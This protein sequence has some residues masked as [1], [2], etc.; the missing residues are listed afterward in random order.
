MAVGFGSI[1]TAIANESAD[2]S[3]QVTLTKPAGLAAGELMIAVISYSD[4]VETQF[5]ALTGWTSHTLSQESG[6]L[7]T[8]IL[9]KVADAGD[10]AASDFTFTKTAGDEVVNLCAA[11]MRITGSGFSGL[12]NITAADSGISSDA[13][14]VY[15]GGVTPTAN[16][17]LIMIATSGGTTATASTYAIVTSDPTWTERAELTS[18]D[19]S[20]DNN[21]VIAT[22]V[23]TEATATGNFSLTW[24]ADPGESVGFLFSI[25]ESTNVTVSP[26]V[27]T[28]T[29][30][31]QAPTVS[32]GAT[33]SP[34]VITMTATIQ[35]PTVTLTDPKWTNTD[36][37]STSWVNQDKN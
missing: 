13:A 27:I 5:F 36:K 28:A 30:S 6:D 12:G 1:T 2:N 33:V 22:A 8:T 17:L 29:L 4:T 15:T 32:G 3:L 26:S 11:L 20:P 9:W 10:A 19:S 31:V 18:I 23:R 14:A 35:A 16:S 37:S 21:L 34:A 24:S 25:Q 7:V